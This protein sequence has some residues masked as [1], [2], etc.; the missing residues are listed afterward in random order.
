MS[1]K[2]AAIWWPP[3][4]SNIFLDTALLVIEPMFILGP[5][6]AD[7]FN[8]L[9]DWV[10]TIVVLLNFSR[11]LVAIIPIKPSGILRSFIIINLFL[12]KIKFFSL[13]KLDDL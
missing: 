8:K 10:I 13:I 6:L 12:I 7:P 4:L 5:D 2:P 9:P 3:P 1:E 11:N